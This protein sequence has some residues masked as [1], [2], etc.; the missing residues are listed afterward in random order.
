MPCSEVVKTARVDSTKQRMAGW[1][2]GFITG[3][4]VGLLDKYGYQRSM[5]GVNSDWIA[6]FAVSYCTKNPSQ[7]FVHAAQDFLK[8]LPAIKE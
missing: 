1:A 4:N 5:T 6:G 7:N 8:Q 3:I 2:Y